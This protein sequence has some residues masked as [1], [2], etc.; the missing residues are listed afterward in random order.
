[1]VI[2]LVHIPF[3]LSALPG[4]DNLYTRRYLWG[5]TPHVRHHDTVQIYYTSL[6]LPDNQP[7]TNMARVLLNTDVLIRPAQM[8]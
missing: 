8:T 1:M 4:A 3:P 5:I 7:V 2:V 6:K